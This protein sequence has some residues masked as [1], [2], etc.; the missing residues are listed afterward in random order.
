MDDSLASPRQFLTKLMCALPSPN[1]SVSTSNPLGDLESQD[2]QLLLTL[3]VV[4]P[5]ELLP[6]LDLLDRGLVTRFKIQPH[7]PIAAG[8]SHTDD[9]TEETILKDSTS[10]TATVYYVQSAQQHRSS[11][12]RTNNRTYDPVPTSHEVR[13]S[14]WHC[15]C[16]AF[17]F[18][19]FPSTLDEDPDPENERSNHSVAAAAIPGTTYARG[20]AT[21]A[22]TWWFGGLARGDAT[23]PV[24]KHLLACVL[25]EKCEMFSAFAET[26]IV[27]VEEA[28][29]WAAGWGG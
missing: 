25:V 17:A 5:N 21:V 22:D 19:A 15:S 7:G 14:A 1:P 24:C 18:A 11:Y 12:S 10:P 27:G 9:P 3:H 4:F 29:G 28:A 23:P 8:P 13:L 6:A 20:S 26:K 16:P 2:R